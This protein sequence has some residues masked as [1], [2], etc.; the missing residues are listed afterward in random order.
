VLGQLLALSS[1]MLIGIGKAFIM[2][3]IITT[4]FLSFP[5]VIIAI[6]FGI[7]NLRH[8]VTDTQEQ[9]RTGSTAYMLLSVFLILFT[10]ALEVIP[11]FLYF[12]KEA[13]QG[14]FTQEAWIAIGGVIS[15][16]FFVSLIITAFSVSLSIKKIDNLQLT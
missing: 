8:E 9:I 5:L 13:K 14:V 3:E 2:L 6:S 10:L 7:S 1:S 11:S 12:L 16:L 4:T 15:L